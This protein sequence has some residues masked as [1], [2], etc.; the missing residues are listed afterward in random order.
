MTD[1]DGIAF[2]AQL[3]Y[4]HQGERRGDRCPPSLCPQETIGCLGP[5]QRDI[6]PLKR[7]VGEETLVDLPART[8][9][10]AHHHLD[11]RRS[12]PLD[13]ATLHLGE[14]IDA[15]ADHTPHALADDQVGTGWCL[16]IVA[17]RL[18]RDVDRTLSQQRFVLGPHRGKS[19]DLG[20]ALATALMV[21]LADDAPAGSYDHR[22]DHGVGLG[23]R[24]SAARQLQTAPHIQFVRFSLHSFLLLRG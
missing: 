9:H 1:E 5:F 17:A 24:L 13:A 20:V 6:G 19:V 11:A 7:V 15:A 23:A 16:T 4:Q 3:V 21:A 18:Q 10:H 12:H 8:F 22:A 2:A 14:G